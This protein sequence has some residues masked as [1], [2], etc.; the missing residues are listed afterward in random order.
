MDNEHR[1]S[2]KIEGRQV[3]ARQGE[4]L[5]DVAQRCGFE[6]PHLCYDEKVSAN[7][8]CSLCLASLD[9]GK[10]VKLCETGAEDGMEVTIVREDL[11]AI[12]R[13]KIEGYLAITGV[14]SGSLPERLPGGTDCQ[15]TR[16]LSPTASTWRRSD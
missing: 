4:S 10:L 3:E 14:M 9:E 16:P 13:D 11:E 2:L 12:R 8:H 15:D 7:G 5:L 1:V 6:V